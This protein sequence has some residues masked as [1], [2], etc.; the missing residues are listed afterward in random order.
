MG[1]KNF[2]NLRQITVKTSLEYKIQIDNSFA[3]NCQSMKQ[4]KYKMI[5]L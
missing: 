3:A 2:F 1:N 5:P 4:D